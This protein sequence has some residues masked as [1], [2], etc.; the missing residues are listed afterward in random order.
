MLCSHEGDRQRYATGRLTPAARLCVHLPA[1]VGRKPPGVP[2]L[3]CPAVPTGATSRRRNI[4]Y[5]SLL[6]S[7][8]LLVS[9]V[10]A[11]EPVA[12]KRPQTGAP[13]T[14]A[15]RQ[16]LLLFLPGG[17]LVVDL[18][19]SSDGK[20]LA[21]QRDALSDVMLKIAAPDGKPAK[22]PDAIARLRQWFDPPMDNEG[23]EPRNAKQE[24]RRYDRND[25][26]LVE[27]EELPRFLVDLKGIGPIFKLDD[28]RQSA[29][30]GGSPLMQL[31]DADADGALSAAEIDAASDRLRLRDADDDQWVTEVELRGAIAE[32]PS[33]DLQPSTAQGPPLYV[34][35]G[36]KPNWGSIYYAVA[37]R[38]QR[39]GEITADCFPLV[40]TLVASLD[41][42]QNH[43]L[44]RIEIEELAT[45]DPHITLNTAF[46]RP[47]EAQR[48]AV[49]QVPD[50]MGSIQQKDPYP[51]QVL[52]LQWGRV[53]LRISASD[54][55]GQLREPKLSQGMLERGDADKN[56]YLDSREFTAAGQVVARHFDVC[57]R[58]HDGKIYVAELEEFLRQWSAPLASQVRVS[59]SG[60]EDAL[61]SSV[62]TVGGRD[63]SLREQ[64]GMAKHLRAMDVDNDGCV[65]AHELPSQL[66]LTL[67]RGDLPV[68]AGNQDFDL[69]GTVLSSSRRSVPDSPPWFAR[70]DINA[71]GDISAREFLG[72]REQFARL[73][74][75]GDGL[76][77]LVE[78]QAAAAGGAP[79]AEPQPK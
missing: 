68:E 25:N 67:R 42:N 45:I 15:T 7:A 74:V 30:S 6:I 65:S 5:F 37:E 59:V 41:K 48:L 76:V 79:V 10:N 62:D 57:D 46:A 3:D 19:I 38:Y 26:G 71:D 49:A 50:E 23:N 33:P 17:P 75:D 14:D 28:S 29:R 44:D 20:S 69:V 35:M 53:A 27:R 55:L 21:A 13:P 8:L 43:T 56:G 18:I 60:G 22:W 73:D 63:L 61:L 72:T 51:G 40:P 24:V 54:L 12:A 58:D 78:A 16:R 11:A 32:L 39:A 34:H 9:N 36:A 2:L 66:V 70:M 4:A 77:N 52:L 47:G 31:L 64:R 1:S